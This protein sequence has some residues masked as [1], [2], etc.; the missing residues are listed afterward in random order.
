[1]RMNHINKSKT[2]VIVTTY[3][4]AEYLKRSLPSIVNQSLEPLEIIIID[5][6]STNNDAQ[7]I[8]N[9]FIDS[10]DIPIVYKR[11][12]NGG[13]S[14]ARNAGIKIA[15][16]EFILFVDSDDELLPDSIEWR[17]EILESLGKNYASVYCSRIE[18]TENKSNKIV[19]VLNF[20][21][22]LD[23]SLVGRINGI[24]GQITNHLFRKS[25]L[26]EVEGYNEFLR[27]NED[28]D[29]IL[30]IAKKSMFR[31]VNKVGFIQHIRGDSWSKTDPYIVYNGVEDF[32]ETALNKKLLPLIEIN[33][34]KKENR[35]SLVKKLLVQREKWSKVKPYIDEAFDIMAPQNIKELIIFSL[36]KF[37]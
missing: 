26:T 29:L 2:S 32:L 30:R 3:N 25:I 7:L 5:D 14:S 4:D 17:Q 34:R 21:G 28:F 12:Y 18:Q 22:M 20:D 6:G 36:N 1:M 24:P 19:K 37:K 9:S 16:G 33:K 31:G 11:K 23:I 8:S 10:T 15:K 27:F 13:P 35:L